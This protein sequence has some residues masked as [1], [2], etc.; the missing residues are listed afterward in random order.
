MIT[1]WIYTLS[2]GDI[3]MLCLWAGIATIVFGWLSYEILNA[4]EEQDP[5]LDA[6]PRS[7]WPQDAPDPASDDEEG[8]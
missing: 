1:N 7:A 5:D 2:E 4:P 8:K 3:A 6:M